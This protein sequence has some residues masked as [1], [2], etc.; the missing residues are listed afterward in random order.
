MEAYQAF[1]RGD[2]AGATRAFGMLADRQPRNA[3]LR[4]M[5]GVCQLQVGQPE[6]ARQNIQAAIDQRPGETRYYYDLG[7]CYRML[8]QP[9]EALATFDRMLEI[10]PG[11]EWGIAGR[12]E[13]LRM[14]DRAEEAMAMLEPYAAKG[15]AEIHPAVAFAD[16]ALSLDRCEAALSVVR[17]F[18]DDERIPQSKRVV[19]AFKLGDLHRKLGQTDDAFKAYAAANAMIVHGY[20]PDQVERSITEM[21][22]AF[23]ASKI[24]R[25]PRSGIDTEKPVFIVGMPRSGTTLVEQILDSHPSFHGAGEMDLLDQQIDRIERS[26]SCEFALMR[27]T[28]LLSSLTLKMGAE[29]YLGVLDAMAPDARRVSDK[30]PTNFLHLGLIALMFPNARVIHCMRD[31]MDT[32]LS[33]FMQYFG[34]RHGYCYDLGLLGHFYGQYQRLMAH[35]KSVLPIEITDVSYEELVANQE[36]ESRRLVEFTGLPWDDAC[37]RFHESTRVASTASNEQVRKPM[38]TSAMQR[39]KKYESHL[40]PLRESLEAAGV[41]V[42]ARDG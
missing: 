28:Q 19:A 22:N 17:P 27:H 37:L 3:E 38:Y 25:M 4:Y 39:W 18:A 11:H 21:I 33:C 29:R 14:L 12:A 1:E 6:I 40:G 26:R 31:P 5:Q 10:S 23:D 20:V 15:F 13:I 34:G 42:S 2:F 24:D 9:D 8:A 35:W 30:L 32:C 41:A 36:S 7:M 16:L